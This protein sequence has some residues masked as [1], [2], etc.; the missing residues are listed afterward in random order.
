[1]AIFPLT[2][3]VPAIIAPAWLGIAAVMTRL[4]LNSA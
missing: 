4:N 3:W 1:V 2:T